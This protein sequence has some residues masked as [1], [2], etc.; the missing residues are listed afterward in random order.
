MPLCRYSNMTI[1]LIISEKRLFKSYQR[2]LRLKKK[3]SKLT[4][5]SYLKE[6]FAPMRNFY[7]DKEKLKVKIENRKG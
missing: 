4:I 6:L 3:N 5:D 7:K 1:E 2:Y